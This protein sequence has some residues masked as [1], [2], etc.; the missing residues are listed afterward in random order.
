MRPKDVRERLPSRAEL[1]TSL[2]EKQKENDDLRKRL[3]EME[4]TRQ[5]EECEGDKKKMNDL[6]E[7]LNTLITAYKQQSNV[8]DNSNN[9]ICENV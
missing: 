8:C 4:K 9:H 3:D 2:H 7:K 1:T 5:Q 6:E